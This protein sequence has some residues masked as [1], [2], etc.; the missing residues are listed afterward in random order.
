[1]NYGAEVT[2][3]GISGCSL[4][5]WEVSFLFFPPIFF[6]WAWVSLYYPGWSGT[7]YIDQA[8]LELTGTCLC[9]PSTRIRSMCYLTLW[10]VSLV[11]LR[12]AEERGVSLPKAAGGR[13]PLNSAC[14]V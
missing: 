9:L 14:G 10:K 11:L 12:V 1:M 7:H 5:K 3:R 8:G 13:Q 6:S 4:E 2:L